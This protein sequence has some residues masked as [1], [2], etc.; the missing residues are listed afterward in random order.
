MRDFE[1][2]DE[3]LWKTL[4][5]D[6]E[7]DELL[8]QKIINQAKMKK[9][10]SY[11]NI[12]RVRV[13]AVLMILILATTA[14][15]FAA[16]Y[17]LTPKQVAQNLGDDGLANAF[18]GKDA[19]A[20]N[21][22]Q[23]CGDYKI[24][25][26]GLV[27][28][29]KISDF[30]SSISDIYPNRTY[31]VVAIANLD[32]K[33]MPDTRDEEYDKVPFFISPLIKGMD[34]REFNIITMNGG[35][36]GFVKDGI[37]YRIVE[38]DDIEI[39]ADR[40]LYLCVTSSTFYDINAFN[41]NEQTG[42]I[43]RNTDYKGVNVLFDLPID[44]SKGDYDKAEKYLKQLEEQQN[45]NT[46]DEEVTNLQDLLKESTL[47]KDS[48]QEVVPDENGKIT[49]KFENDE[50]STDI[51]YL[52]EE[53]QVGLSDNYYITEDDYYKNILVFSRDSD[54]TIKVMTYRNKLN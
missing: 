9:S 37:M 5:S 4:S 36:S 34:P 14:T 40:G 21:S 19:L 53:N 28:G 44:K 10:T 22:S 3:V 41:Y 38:C 46:S 24:T 42:E 15:V 39:F 27:S 2:I 17:L 54:G 33:A 18:E 48:V 20:I 52:F 7:P 35:Y 43:T 1:K 30:K 13:I 51:K 47:V 49:Y 45:A 11:F 25:L 29:E 8:N 6:I 32:G 26:L 50:I 31:A 12:K 16:W 23:V